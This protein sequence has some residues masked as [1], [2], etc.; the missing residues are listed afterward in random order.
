M[1]KEKLYG[2]V[3]EEIVYEILKKKYGNKVKDIRKNPRKIGD[4][5]VG[6]KIIE[7]K[8]QSEDNPGKKFDKFDY[9][10]RYISLSKTA[11]KFLKK[12]PN[13]YQAYIVYRLNEKYYPNPEFNFPKIAILRG[14][15]LKD[16]KIEAPI[17]RLKTLKP[18]WENKR[19]DQKPVPELIWK[20]KSKGKNY[21]KKHNHKSTIKNSLS[22]IQV[23]SDSTNC[24]IYSI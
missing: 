2:I 19:K 21:E 5:Q 3:A 13:R 6:N 10:A 22:N 14:T 1:V 18:F 16:C 7:V 23:F 20:K 11:V 15:E 24:I 4:F 9:V 12:H 17:V 8:G